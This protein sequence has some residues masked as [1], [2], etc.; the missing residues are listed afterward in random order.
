VCDIIERIESFGIDREQLSRVL[1]KDPRPLT[2]SRSAASIT[3][4][5]LGVVEE[6]WQKRSAPRSG[7]S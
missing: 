5:V 4:I 2:G 1:K 3:L 6:Q 7:D